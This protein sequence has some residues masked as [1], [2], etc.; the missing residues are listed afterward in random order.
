M[1]MSDE[2]QVPQPTPNLQPPAVNANESRWDLLTA[3]SVLPPPPS[4][5]S[6]LL[7][8][9]VIP[10]PSPI[11]AWA[12]TPSASSYAASQ[13]RGGR[14]GA[15]GMATIVVLAFV[16]TALCA[17]IGCLRK[18]RA[19]SEDT[20]SGGLSQ[21][22][23]DYEA[24]VTPSSKMAVACSASITSGSEDAACEGESATS[25]Q[26]SLSRGVSQVDSN[27]VHHVNSR[28]EDAI[29]LVRQWER[30]SDSES[31]E[32]S[33]KP[34]IAST[35]RADNQDSRRDGRG[36]EG[37]QSIPT[38]ERRRL[39]PITRRPAASDAGESGAWS[40]AIPPISTCSR[41]PT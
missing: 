26:Q 24:L 37:D 21:G 35:K 8:W 28:S 41:T 31:I 1:T 39:R 17:W 4:S 2:A 12:P 25:A 19:K 18:R 9:T 14:L 6:P 36:L 23:R 10:L 27:D 3:T 15:A 22:G 29:N 13:E 40:V 7:R 20:L 16:L 33:G 38:T 32:R 30:D 34:T 11:D 5:G